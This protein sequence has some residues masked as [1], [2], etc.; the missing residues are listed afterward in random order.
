[1]I[2]K[3]V[4][5]GRSILTFPDILRLITQLFNSKY[6]FVLLLKRNVSIYLLH[7]TT[8]ICDSVTHFC[9]IPTCP[10]GQKPQHCALHTYIQM[11][12]S[13]FFVLGPYSGGISAFLRSSI[14]PATSPC[15]LK[16][17]VISP[18]PYMYMQICLNWQV[19]LL[20][21]A[22]HCSYHRTYYYQVNN[23]NKLTLPDLSD[24]VLPSTSPRRCS[25]LLLMPW[26]LVLV[27]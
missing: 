10:T 11:F 15:S 19:P 27:G 8:P 4:I 12:E 16:V 24:T 2:S 3:D 25:P 22:V 14:Y 1:M 26:Y 21:G 20:E 23:D 6:H 18:S 7:L 13:F 17:Q 9:I 5:L